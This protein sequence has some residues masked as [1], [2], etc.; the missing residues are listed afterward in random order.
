MYYF[1]KLT[2]SLRSWGSRL[3]ATIT[4]HAYIFAVATVFVSPT[5]KWTTEQR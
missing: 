3:L 5:T 1:L 2:C 4:N